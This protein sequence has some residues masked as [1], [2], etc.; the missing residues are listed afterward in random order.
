MKMRYLVGAA[1]V[2]LAAVTSARANL[3][4]NGGLE[5][6][7]SSLPN[8]FNL[9]TLASGS[10][11]LPG[12]KITNGTVDLVPGTT[13]AHTYWANTQG[14]Y[15]VDLI[16]TPGIGGISQTVKNLTVG[17]TYT[18]TFDF[19]VNPE[20][21]PWNEVGTTKVLRVQ[22]LNNKNAVILTQDFSDTNGA[23]TDTDMGWSTKSFSFV[24]TTTTMTLKLAALAPLDLPSGAQTS[25]IFAGPAIDNLD[26]EPGGGRPVPE[27]ASLSI[28]GAGAAAL[29]LRRRRKVA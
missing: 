9:I 14:D 17:N 10:S 23:R 22:T 4:T 13:A 12:W 3:L 15:S 28:L 8:K 20:T 7:T 16:G 18:L 21:G 6:A 19:S 29:L 11:K 5:P 26:L 27:P 25:K 24:A 1:L 2:S